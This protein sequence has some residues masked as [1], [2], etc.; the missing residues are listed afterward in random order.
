MQKKL[1]KTKA[2]DPENAIRVKRSAE[3][4][5]VSTRT[6]YRVILCDEKISKE[7]IERVMNI[8]M[9]LQEGENLLVEAVKKTVPVE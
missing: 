3:I 2:R 1:D 5:G 7:T 9:Q 6:V 4:A 8:Y